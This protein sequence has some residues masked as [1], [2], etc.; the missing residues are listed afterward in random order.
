MYDKKWLGTK[1]TG[2]TEEEHRKIDVSG[3][4]RSNG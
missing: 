3:V 1:K 4:E 2:L